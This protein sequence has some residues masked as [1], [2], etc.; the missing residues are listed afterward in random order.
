MKNKKWSG[1]RR[2]VRQQMDVLWTTPVSKTCNDHKNWDSTQNKDSVS[3]PVNK[4]PLKKKTLK[5]YHCR[6]KIGAVNK[7]CGIHD[8]RF[9]CQTTYS[10][11]ST[12][13]GKTGQAQPSIV[14]TNQL[15]AIQINQLANQ[16]ALHM[17]QHILSQSNAN[18][19]YPSRNNT[20]FTWTK[21]F[22]PIEQKKLQTFAI[23]K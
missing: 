21:C 11:C 16:P 15:P 14:R 5:N 4:P 12:G 22:L 6:E 23:F 10:L 17:N 7:V 1:N 8:T 18:L 19:P 13:R 2:K 9:V 20:P 3:L